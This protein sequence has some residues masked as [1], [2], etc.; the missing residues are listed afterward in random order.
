[1]MAERIDNLGSADEF[2]FQ[3]N[4]PQPPSTTKKVDLS[5]LQDEPTSSRAWTLEDLTSGTTYTAATEALPQVKDPVELDLNYNDTQSLALFGSVYTRVAIAIQRVKDEYPNGFLVTSFDAGPPLTIPTSGLTDPDGGAIA[6]FDPTNVRD[7]EPYEFVVFSADQVLTA[8]KILSIT[9]TATE[10][11]F[12]LVGDPDLVTA[13]LSYAIS[14]TRSAKDTFFVQYPYERDIIE[15]TPGRTNIWPSTAGVTDLLLFAGSEYDEFVNAE[16]ALAL[17]A[18]TVGTPIPSNVLWRSLTPQGMKYLDNDDQILEKLVLTMGMSFDA[19]ARY[20]NQMAYAHT[21]GYQD[22]DHVPRELVYELANMWGWTLSHDS[23]GQDLTE[24]RLSIFDSYATGVT[25]SLPPIS[26]ADINFERWRRIVS[27][28]VRIW[29]SKGTRRALQT[30]FDIYG[31][32]ADLLVLKEYV[33]FSDVAFVE[34]LYLREIPTGIFLNTGNTKTR[35]WIDPEDASVETI[36]N[37]PLYNARYLDVGISEAEAVFRDVYDWA[38]TTDLTFTDVNGVAIELSARTDSIYDFEYE[39]V[40]AFVPSDGSHR[41]AHGYPLLE[42][43]YTSYLANSGNAYKIG[44]FTPFVEFI[45]ENYLEIVRQ[46]IPASS[47]LLAQGTIIE[48]LPFHREKHVWEP[49]GDVDQPFNEELEIKVLPPVGVKQPNPAAFVDTTSTSA[50][51]QLRPVAEIDSMPVRQTTVT[52]PEAT[53]ETVSPASFKSTSAS[54]NIPTQATTAD[55]VEQPQDTYDLVDVPGGAVYE[56]DTPV[57]VSYS[58]TSGTAAFTAFSESALIVTN[59]NKFD[60]YLSAS[61]MSSSGANRISVELF[62][63]LS[64]EDRSRISSSA[65]TVMQTSY[66]GSDFTPQS[67]RTGAYRLNTVRGLAVGDQLSAI[68]P[69][70]QY[71]NTLVTIRAIYTDT[72]TIVTAPAIGLDDLPVGRNAVKVGMRTLFN[73]PVRVYLIQALEDYRVDPNAVLE[74]L[75]YLYSELRPPAERNLGDIADYGIFLTELSRKYGISDVNTRA[76]FTPFYDF[77]TSELAGALIVVPYIR[78]NPEKF[79]LSNDGLF[80]G[81]RIITELASVTLSKVNE[82][83][84]WA[85]PVQSEVFTQANQG[86]FVGWPADDSLVGIEDLNDAVISGSVEIGGLDSLN[87]DILQD[88]EEYFIRWEAQAEV[89]SGF[90]GE[91]YFETIYSGRNAV[92]S[93]YPLKIINDIYY[94]GDYFVYM[95]TSKEA[96]VTTQPLESGATD[97]ASVELAW[98]GVG[99]ADLLEVQFYNDG[100]ATGDPPT[101]QLNASYDTISAAQWFTSTTINTPV[102]EGADDRTIYTIQ[103]TLEPETWYWWRIRNTKQKLTMFGYVLESVTHT[104]PKLFY[105]GPFLDRDSEEGV[106]PDIPEPPIKPPITG[107]GGT[108][109]GDN[110]IFQ[111]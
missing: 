17:S 23:K 53:V 82:L 108:G 41:T 75:A 1:M 15:G 63:R 18:D 89:T 32:P 2:G 50:N 111:G 16:L 55:Y 65:F 36:T 49:E 61:N 45:E 103:T 22:Y 109:D 37:R 84:D 93:N 101:Q 97:T 81:N 43:V 80:I 52:R 42:A 107:G 98:R 24:Y 78:D 67:N 60:L 8:H 30:V 91:T 104:E 72:N 74:A 92:G 4:K 11:S 54:V 10:T 64:E 26:P 48:N 76:A 90:T 29:K 66:E 85:S 57:I 59:D 19:I 5:E 56:V 12:T 70:A 51:K 6:N 25:D 3:L 62:R 94:Y 44:D 13:G 34:P 9:A 31:V 86:N 87:A 79:T 77:T 47:R 95:R 14:P 21:M 71:V 28:L 39:L 88:K 73:S 105:T 46:L 33:Y 40:N 27:S 7:W 20:Q 110:P 38:S 58:A 100:P 99:D 69:L 106:N 68:T 35:V 102:K 83:F 96:I